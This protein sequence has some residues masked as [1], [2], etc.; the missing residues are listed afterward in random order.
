MNDLSPS[1]PL[2]TYLMRVPDPA[3]GALPDADDAAALL[4][5][6]DDVVLDEP[7]LATSVMA[8]R[9]AAPR[10][11]RG[12]VMGVGLLRVGSVRALCGTRAVQLRQDR[13]AV[14]LVATDERPVQPGRRGV[15][16]VGG[17][18]VVLGDHPV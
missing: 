2:M 18:G 7:Q 8:A 10:R 6:L 16:G 15:R 5:V 1:V 13:D 3:A 9:I 14:Q 17:P 4:D 11:R 12:R